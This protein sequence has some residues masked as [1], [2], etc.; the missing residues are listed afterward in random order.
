MVLNS[1][2][3][4][5]KYQAEASEIKASLEL[6]EKHP[7][8]DGHFPGQP[9]VPGVCMMQAVKE[10]VERHLD[11]KLILQEADNMKFLAVLDPRTNKFVEAAITVKQDQTSFA[12][13]ASLFADTVTF[14]KLKAVLNSLTHQE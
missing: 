1:L 14:F 13:N 12:V 4:V 6:N 7:I 8:F 5:K 10:L 9:V 11:R 2:F 3:V